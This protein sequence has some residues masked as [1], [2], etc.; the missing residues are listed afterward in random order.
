MM[1]ATVKERLKW[2]REHKEEIL[3]AFI[4]KHG[5]DP[6]DAIMVEKQRTDGGWEW[7]VTKR[8]KV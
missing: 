8:E 5:F 3:E 1:D 4:A 7:Y 2:I 6:D